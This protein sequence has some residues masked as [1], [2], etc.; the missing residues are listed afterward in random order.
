M[1]QE[2]VDRFM[3]KKDEISAV[4]SD[5]HP[6]EYIDIVASVISV[7]HDPDSYNSIDPDRIHEIDDGSRHG[8]LVYVIAE[9]GYQPNDYWYVKV[10]Y[11][12]CS[13]CD[14]L[15]S[16]RRCSDEKPTAEQVEDYMTLALHIVQGMK[17]MVDD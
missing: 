10:Y 1:I 12:S 15:Q 4:F 17:K 7:L 3:A 16:I 2:F 9:S 5:K 13:G 11:G 14:T 6:H 8:T